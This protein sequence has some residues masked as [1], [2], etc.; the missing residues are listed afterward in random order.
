MRQNLKG[1]NELLEAKHQSPEWSMQL[2]LDRREWPTVVK[3]LV[4]CRVK[5][6]A[7]INNRIEY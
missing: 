3:G 1:L 6:E 4:E 5:A 2:V 7:Y